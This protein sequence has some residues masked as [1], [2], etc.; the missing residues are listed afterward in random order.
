MIKLIGYIKRRLN[1][2]STYAAVVAAISG[3][4]MLPAPW[5]YVAVAVGV[6]G[7]LVPTQKGC[8]E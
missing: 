7:V 3:A 6:I 2:K 5:S 4:A 8:G 1:E